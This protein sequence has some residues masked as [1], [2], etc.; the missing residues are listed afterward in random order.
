[1]KLLLISTKKPS[2]Y[3]TI[4]LSSLFFVL[5]LSLSLSLSVVEGRIR[6]APAGVNTGSWPKIVRTRRKS[7]AELIRITDNNDGKKFGYSNTGFT[8]IVEA[9]VQHDNDQEEE[10]KKKEEEEEEEENVKL[11]GINH[12]VQNAQMQMMMNAQ[13]ATYTMNERGGDNTQPNLL[14][15]LNQKYQKIQ[16]EETLDGS[17]LLRAFSMN[18]SVELREAGDRMSMSFKLTDFEERDAHLF[19]MSMEITTRS[20]TILDYKDIVL[21]QMDS[22]SMSMETR[23]AV[24]M[25]LFDIEREGMIDSVCLNFLFLSL[26]V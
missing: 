25:Q 17:E 14:S 16:M 18:M 22:L 8:S 9:A 21:L 1:M 13:D 11:E 3:I 24:S 26:C 15:K 19:S 7:S 2:R 23:D 6:Q 12:Y 20:N 5:S 10:S 4:T